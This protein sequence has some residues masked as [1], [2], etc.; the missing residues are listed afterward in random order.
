MTR[1]IQHYQI[2]LAEPVNLLKS[3]YRDA[4]VLAMSHF[5]GGSAPPFTTFEFEDAIPFMVALVEEFKEA[6]DSLQMGQV[7]QATQMLVKAGIDHKHA[8]RIAG[9]VFAC[10]TDV[11][12]SFFPDLTFGEYGAWRMGFVDTCDLLVTR[13]PDHAIPNP[14]EEAELDA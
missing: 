13:L 4:V 11:I 9:E 10:M 3:H 7:P 8:V 14:Y 2:S 5:S 6:P 12:G 1:E